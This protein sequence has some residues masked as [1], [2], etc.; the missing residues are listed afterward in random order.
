MAKKM[1]A[2][3]NIS[4]EVVSAA[5]RGDLESLE[6]LI[7]EWI[8]EDELPPNDFT[9]KK[10]RYALY[11]AICRNQVPAAWLLLKRGAIADGDAAEAAATATFPATRPE[12]CQ[13]LIDHGWH[14]NEHTSDG[15]TMLT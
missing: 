6:S 9:P 15:L 1:S 8:A 2:A 13:L 7:D 14:I 3:R 10:L 12:T 5:G 11:T 4:E